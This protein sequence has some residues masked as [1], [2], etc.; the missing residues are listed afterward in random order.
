MPFTALPSN[1]WMCDLYNNVWI[2]LGTV[3]QLLQY[4][5]LLDLAVYGGPVPHPGQLQV[6]VLG[7]ALDQVLA[8][9]TIA[10]NTHTAN[11]LQNFVDL[12]FVVISQL[13][14]KVSPQ[15][16]LPVSVCVTLNKNF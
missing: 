14:G 12:E 15:L 5:L 13:A 2:V 3:R 8:Q 6:L 16:S 10:H 11:H 7:D 9:M 4:E 1:I